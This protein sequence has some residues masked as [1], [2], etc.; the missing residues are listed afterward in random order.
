LGASLQSGALSF[1]TLPFPS[2]PDKLIECWQS[3]SPQKIKASSPSG[4]L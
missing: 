4:R 2:F 1:D 3:P